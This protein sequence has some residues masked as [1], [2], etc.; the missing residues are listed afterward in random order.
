V[1]G[2]GLLGHLRGDGGRR[3]AFR[4]GVRGKS[5]GLP[6]A[7]E[8]AE[9]DYAPGGTER[10]LAHVA[11][12]VEWKGRSTKR[13]GWCWPTPRRPAG[14]SLRCRRRKPKSWS[15]D[16]KDEGLHDATIIGELTGGQPG[17][18]VVA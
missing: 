12:I 6:R 16:L 15:L 4:P 10:N 2:F 7:R 3:K 17:R 8:L 1:T 5:A 13:C 11:P 18:I 9:A 14:Y